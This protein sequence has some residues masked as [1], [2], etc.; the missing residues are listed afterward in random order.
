MHRSIGSVISR[1]LLC[2]AL[3]VPALVT[4]A[5]SS[6]SADSCN[7]TYWPETGHIQT[8][9]YPGSNTYYVT[10]QFALTSDELCS[11]RALDP[12]LQIKI[13]IGGFQVPAEWDSWTFTSN[14]PYA[15][16]ESAYRNPANQPNPTITGI[17]TSHLAAGTNYNVTFT[18]TAGLVSGQSPT[19]AFEW[20]PAHWADLTN[21]TQAGS[22]IV[23]SIIYDLAAW[24]IFADG[25]EAATLFGTQAFNGGVPNGVL[26]L[27]GFRWLDWSPTQNPAALSSSTTA[28]PAAPSNPPANYLTDRTILHG[29][30]GS[31]YVM[32]GGAKFP[33]GSMSEFSS[34]GYSTNGMVNLDATN[35]NAIPNTPRNG[36]VLR[37]GGGQ[38]Y[39]VAGGAKFYFG[40]WGEYTG[41]GYSSSSYVNVPQAPLNAIG[42]APGNKPSNGTII[43]APNGSLSIVV[44][45]VKFQFGTM[46]E[47]RSLGYSDGQMV[48]VSQSPYDGI[49]A[50]STSSPPSSGTVLRSGGGQI[51]VVAGGAKFYFGTMDEYHGQGYADYQW[52]NVPQAPLDSIGD[53]PGN[54]PVNGTAVL[55]P[56]DSVYVIA[57]GVKWYFPT[58]T[59]FDG[60]GYQGYVPVSQAP[61]NSIPTASATNLPAY[62]TLL[63]TGSGPNIYII[64]GGQLMTFQSMTQFTNDGYSMSHV[65]WVPQSVIDQLPS[66]GYVS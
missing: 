33:F 46:T 57:G 28:P 10:M 25:A 44:G 13:V 64:Q 32:A 4:F 43:Q 3:A 36:T 9:N 20:V 8:T 62:G 48:R 31:L 56:D 50:A 53:A 1:L 60:D 42:D 18:W 39:V 26:F 49:A 66:G 37:S 63:T 27:D 47:Y 45:G 65:A 7:G 34:L 24:C 61:I 38:I 14:L 58:M 29:P 51:Y 12:Y 11:L 41:Q 15:E 35:I 59:E 30:D 19:I 5:S 54:I 16:K 21:R 55:A 52:F 22:C 6:A 40:S 17:P 23:G 2:L